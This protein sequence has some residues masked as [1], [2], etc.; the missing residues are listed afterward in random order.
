MTE[1]TQVV[2]RRA[3]EREHTRAGLISNAY[4]GGQNE[5]SVYMVNAS[6]SLLPPGGSLALYCTEHHGNVFDSLKSQGVVVIP[7]GSV[8]TTLDWDAGTPSAYPRALS[9]YVAQLQR[10]N[11]TLENRVD[12]LEQELKEIRY[13]LPTIKKLVGEYT[14]AS[15]RVSAVVDRLGRKYDPAAAWNIALEKDVITGPIDDEEYSEIL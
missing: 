5:G 11:Q 9:S 14:S 7:S 3:E 12:S 8:T 2:R 6:C 13:Y 10:V 1:Q 4:V 15:M